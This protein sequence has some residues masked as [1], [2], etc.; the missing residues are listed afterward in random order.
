M[1]RIG[2]YDICDIG[3]LLATS[4]IYGKVQGIGFESGLLRI[5]SYPLLPT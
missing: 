4:Q 3:R 5:T 1:E 2:K